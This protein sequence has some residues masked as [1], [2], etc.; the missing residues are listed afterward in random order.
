MQ[1]SRLIRRTVLT[2]SRRTDRSG[3]HNRPVRQSPGRRASA[4]YLIAPVR[5]CFIRRVHSED[6]RR[7]AASGGSVSGANEANELGRCHPNCK[8]GIE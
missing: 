7:Q 4:L 8:E 6:H 1:H 5:L 3:E 2:G